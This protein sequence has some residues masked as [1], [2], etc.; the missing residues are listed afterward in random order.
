MQSR[1]TVHSSTL[2]ISPDALVSHRDVLNDIPILP[3][4]KAIQAKCPV[5]IDENL[6]RQNI[7]DDNFVIVFLMTKCYSS[8]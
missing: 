6:Q 4:F 5:L 3:N 1:N 7:N 8:N 2:G